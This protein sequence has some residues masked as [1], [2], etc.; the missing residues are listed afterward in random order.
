MTTKE[1]KRPFRLYDTK[2]K[3]FLCSRNYSIFKNAHIGG[4]IQ[5]RWAPIGTTIEVIDKAHGEAL[6]GQYTRTATTVRFTNVEVG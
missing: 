6:R 5:A 2:T 3:K 4:L 1:T